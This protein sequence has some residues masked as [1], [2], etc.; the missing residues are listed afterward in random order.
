MFL[1][2]STDFL[3]ILYSETDASLSSSVLFY[4]VLSLVVTLMAGLMIMVTVV[5]RSTTC[6]HL[7]CKIIRFEAPKR[8]QG[9][10]MKIAKIQVILIISTKY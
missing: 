8:Q 2:Q 6:C 7:S 3:D 1:S 5:I 9:R 10:E 4:Y